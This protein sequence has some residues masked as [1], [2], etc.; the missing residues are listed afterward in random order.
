MTRGSGVSDSDGPASILPLRLETEL[1][2]DLAAHWHFRAAIEASPTGMLVV[3]ARATIVLVNAQIEQL[4]GFSRAELV[5]QRIEVLVPE[6]FRA[7]HPQRIMDYL[8]DPH[9]RPMGA[10]RDLYGMRKNGQEVPIEIGLN[11][12]H[13][14]EGAFVLCSV[15]DISAHKAAERELR[16][17]R[18]RLEEFVRARTIELEVAT[19]AAES[20]NRAKSEFL[21]NMSHELRTPMHAILAYARLGLDLRPADELSECLTHIIDSGQRLLTLLNGLL[22]LSKLEAAKMTLEIARHDLEEIAREVLRE[23][24]PLIVSKRLLVRVERAVGCHSCEAEVDRGLLRKVFANILFNAIELSREGQH[25]EVRFA[26]TQIQLALISEPVPALQI[27]IQ[28]EAIGIPPAEL[29]QVFE[30]FVQ[31]TKTQRS[32]GGIGLGLAICKQ[33]LDLHRGSVHAS[34]NQHGGATFTVLVPV[35]TPVEPEDRVHAVQGSCRSA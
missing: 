34:N 35:V 15:V 16:Q 8:Q 20:A 2:R 25:I 14:P 11:P 3:D 31:S 19:N 9:A 22:D 23:L 24:R 13:T 30:K 18:E 6:R 26:P 10:G 32:G 1:A 5:G 21:A 29:E 27:E 4:F 7:S 28:D 33:V 17:H 12:M